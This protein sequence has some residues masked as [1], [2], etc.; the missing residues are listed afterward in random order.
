MLPSARLPA[1]LAVLLLMPELMLS[2]GC[3]CCSLL[4]LLLTLPSV[5]LPQLSDMSCETCFCSCCQARLPP[6]PCPSASIHVAK[7]AQFTIVLAASEHF[8]YILLS[9]AHKKAK[10]RAC[11]LPWLNAGAFC[12]SC[13]IICSYRLRVASSACLFEGG[14]LPQLL[15][16]CLLSKLEVHLFTAKDAAA[17]KC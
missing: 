5:R 3:L 11:M 1:V 9:N 15:R 2:H 10:R 6:I 12:L 17:L 14:M 16:M 13:L 7:C 4:I 8:A